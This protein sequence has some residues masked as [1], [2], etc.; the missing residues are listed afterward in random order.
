M[1]HCAYI[2]TAA[3]WLLT[4]GGGGWEVAQHRG[5]RYLTVRILLG[6]S[7]CLSL[8]ERQVADGLL[9]YYLFDKTSEIV[10]GSFLGFQ[11]DNEPED[12]INQDT[13]SAKE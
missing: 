10:V 3:R 4:G 1:N 11:R 13:P 12:Y 5:L 6:E 7:I 8:K 2:S 9:D